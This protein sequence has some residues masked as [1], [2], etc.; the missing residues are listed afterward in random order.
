MDLNLTAAGQAR[1]V[2]SL[3]SNR[4]MEMP[5]VGLEDILCF[6]ILPEPHTSGENKLQGWRISKTCQSLSRLVGRIELNRDTQVS[7]SCFFFFF[8]ICITSC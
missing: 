2:G 6:T 5:N 4:E 3:N 8:N 1:C 7:V